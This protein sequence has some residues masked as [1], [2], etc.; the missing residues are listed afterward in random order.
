MSKPIK[1]TRSR[2]DTPRSREA[3][4]KRRTFALKVAAGIKPTTAAREVGYAG[5]HA[6]IEASRLGSRPDVAA[7]IDEARQQAFDR[8]QVDV[9]VYFEQLHAICTADLIELLDD[10]GNVRPLSSLTPRARMALQSLD[11]VMQ[12]AR[13]GD[14]VIDLVLKPRF[15]SKLEA[16]VTMLKARGRLVNKIEKGAPGEFDHL[17]RDQLR[18]VIEKELAPA[19]GLR[20]VKSGT[21]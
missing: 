20:L 9:N 11:L 21:D 18:D 10:R 17:T 19:A 15:Y 14:G 16:L 6:N 7:L 1:A 8:L 3:A 2:H 5:K 13:A 4:A 12:N